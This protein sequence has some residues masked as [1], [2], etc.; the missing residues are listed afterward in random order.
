MIGKTISHYHILDKIGA[1]G[2]GIVYKAEDTKLRRTVAIKFLPPEFVQ[3][4]K[5]KTRF[6]K[7][8]QTASGVSG[9]IHVFHGGSGHSRR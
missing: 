9:P 1:G 2:M 8:A 3:D 5:A 4:Q 7:E 6:Y